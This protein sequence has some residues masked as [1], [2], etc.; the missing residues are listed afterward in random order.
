MRRS[1]VVIRRKLEHIALDDIGVHAH[2]AV[3][4]HVAV[5][6]KPHLVASF[7]DV[8]L[9]RNRRFGNLRFGKRR[10]VKHEEF[11]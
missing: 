5:A 11:I 10:V 7:R 3:V 8:I 2:I 4:E 1:A 6:V 9:S